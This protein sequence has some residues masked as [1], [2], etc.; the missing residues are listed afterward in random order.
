MKTKLA[1][2]WKSVVANKLLVISSL[3]TV[4]VAVVVVGV[5]LSTLHNKKPAKQQAEVI[6]V[7][8][9]EQ[10]NLVGAQDAFKVCDITVTSQVKDIKI[11]FTDGSEKNNRISGVPFKVKLIDPSKSA[12]LIAYVLEI[13]AIDEEID[14]LPESERATSVLNIKKAEALENYNKALAAMD[15]IELVDDDKDGEIYQKDMKPGEFTLCCYSVDKYVAID[16]T[17]LA[18]VRNKVEY[19]VVDNIKKTFKV[20]TESEDI[21]LKQ[22]DKLK[23]TVEFIESASKQK[24]VT[25][26]PKVD[27]K[28]VSASSTDAKKV[29]LTLEKVTSG[30]A[31]S[32]P[33][34]SD[35]NTD[36]KPSDNGGNA[37]GSQTSAVE[38]RPRPVSSNSGTPSDTKTF[39]VNVALEKQSATETKATFKAS[40]TYASGTCIVNIDS[41]SVDGSAKTGDT[42][43]LTAGEHSVA[44]TFTVTLTEGSDKYTGTASETF[45]VNVE[46][47]SH[48][49]K[50]VDA[51]GSQLYKDE[52]CTQ[53]ATE[54][55]Y[56]A[57]P[58]AKYYKPQTVY[59]GWQNINGARYYFDKNGTKVTGS[60]VI[61]GV[62]YSFGSDGI[63]LE[64]GTGI[65][66]SKWQGSIDWSKVKGNVSFA[67][68]RCAFRSTGSASIIEDPMYREYMKG[69]KANGIP[70]GVYFYST[71]L[72][73]AEAVEEASAAVALVK[74]MGG[75]SLP[76]Y[77]DMEDSVRGQNKLTN[78][79][80]TAICKAF[81]E[82]V[83][84]AGY[85]PGVYASTSWLTYSINANEF[86]G[87]IQI[88]VAQYKDTCTYKGRYNI[89]QYGTGTIDGI[90]TKVDMNIRY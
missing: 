34:N 21:P 54:A 26:T 53:E 37:G 69:A 63:Q 12:E 29:T 44:V 8:T 31:G 3:I 76:I 16:F 84:S 27:T 86:S 71:A 32:T 33:S 35:S 38:F 83:R 88:W 42:V 2:L 47:P 89:W 24:G 7:I 80:R 73:E 25:A 6:P 87:D 70:T 51:T 66:V 46:A 9:I 14:K 5:V 17:K 68:I 55:D 50:L 19:K 13:N 4:F 39:D 10:D 78:A 22:V 49:G 82:V 67:I 41:I 43:E 20:Y 62:M 79:E 18:T 11:Y 23:D 40:T 59:Y 61:N 75:C 15:G 57:K 48:F 72:N 90:N 52:A 81:C 28:T 1:K 74:E 64:T 30:D 77:I 65:D 58:D 85:T 60:Q 45:S 36:S 56:K